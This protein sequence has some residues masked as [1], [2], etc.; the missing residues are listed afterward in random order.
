[1]GA[2]GGSPPTRGELSAA[3]GLVLACLLGVYSAV[4]S[5]GFVFDD[6]ALV[7]QN[8]LT[9]HPSR[10]PEAFQTDLWKTTGVNQF[11]GY[12]R[13]LMLLDLMADRALFGLSP[14]AH[15][16][17]S[18]AWHL[19]AVGLFLT[20]LRRLVAPGPALVGAAI[21]ALHPVQSEAV[22]WIA[23]RNDL[24]AAAFVFAAV[25]ALLPRAV[26]LPRAC[27]G[28]TLILLGLLSKESAMLA[29][30]ALFFLDVARFRRPVGW[31]RYLAASGA[32]SAWWALRTAA[33]IPAASVPSGPELAYLLAQS[34]RLAAH[35][36]SL[37]VVPY[38]L[39][40]GGFLT[41]LSGSP[42]VYGLLA[43]FAFALLAAVRRGGA[44]AWAG[45]ALALVA[46]APALLAVGVRGQVGERYLYLPLAGLALAIASALPNRRVVLAALAPVALAWALVIHARLP[47]WTSDLTLWE[48]ADA[49]RPSP[50]THHSLAAVMIDQGATRRRHPAL[51][52]GARR[53]PPLPARVPA[54][55]RPA[56]E[57]RRRR[58]RR[59][60]RAPRR[61]GPLSQERRPRRGRR[62]SGAR[63]GRP[64]PR[65]A[66][67]RWREPGWQ[68]RP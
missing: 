15:H 12:Y 66:P 36:G 61:P 20:L 67:H 26:G 2:V 13:P 35:Y 42:R 45:L 19:L 54:R 1:M 24:M 55:R 60:G 47:A 44:L 56:T 50:Y 10:W 65:P 64:C 28:G 40:I 43:V 29:P 9:G 14:A 30:V 48:A 4:G 39:S 41:Y 34:P 31:P 49:E 38:P 7:I 23:A 11:S 52:V 32:V 5:A 62:P 16:L 63:C 57:G 6:V 21:F 25:L 3:T 51:P 46:F 58:R 68:R 53:P 37:L 27:A 18:L 59:A 22:V 8:T 17:H 33:E